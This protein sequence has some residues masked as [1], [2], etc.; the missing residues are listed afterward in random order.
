MLTGSRM[1]RPRTGPFRPDS[2]RQTAALQLGG[3]MH[4]RTS[5]PQTLNP[6]RRRWAVGRGAAPSTGTWRRS[7]SRTS[8]HPPP[9]RT[10]PPHLGGKTYKVAPPI[11]CWESRRNV[12]SGVGAHT[13]PF[14]DQRQLF[15]AP[16]PHLV[17]YM[18]WNDAQEDSCWEL[19]PEGQ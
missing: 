3:R 15:F 7:S 8:P 5:A 2:S 13:S 19:T 11:A 14:S 4:K 18:I 17:S 9:P 10:P 6:R 12:C 1:Q 16:E